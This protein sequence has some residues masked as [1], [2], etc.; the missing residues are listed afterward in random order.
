VNQQTGSVDGYALVTVRA[1]RGET[2][3]RDSGIENDDH[4]RIEMPEL[5]IGSADEVEEIPALPLPEVVDT[6]AVLLAGLLGGGWRPL[7]LDASAVREL[8]P[9]AAPL[10]LALLRAKREAGVAARIQGASAGLRR[11]FAGH[12]LAAYFAGAADTAEALFTCPDREE[13]GFSPSPR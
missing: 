12:E 7:V 6:P 13:L 8:Q 4:G 9:S 10:L 5:M 11:R 1:P 2:R 3:R